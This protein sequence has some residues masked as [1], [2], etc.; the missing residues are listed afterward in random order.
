M[1]IY[2][3]KGKRRHSSNTRAT[4]I[5]QSLSCEDVTSLAISKDQQSVSPSSVRSKSC[6]Q[7]RTASAGIFYNADKK[8]SIS[9]KTCSQTMS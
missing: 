7:K 4:A 6:G 9:L 1:F 2:L 3:R 5:S 8:D